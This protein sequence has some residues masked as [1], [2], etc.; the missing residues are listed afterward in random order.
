MA[1]IRTPTKKEAAMSLSDDAWNALQKISSKTKADCWFYLVYDGSRFYVRD[2]END[3]DLDL[4]EGVT[5]LLD[6]MV[7]PPEDAFYGLTAEELAAFRH[8]VR[9]ISDGV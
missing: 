4:R 8:L 1:S 7:E 9:E 6:A 2:L 5:Q 3:T